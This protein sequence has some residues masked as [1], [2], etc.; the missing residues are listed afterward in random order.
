MEHKHLNIYTTKPI[1]LVDTPGLLSEKI[2]EMA[3]LVQI[4]KWMK[5]NGVKSV[6]RLIYTDRSNDIRISNPRMKC[7]EIFKALCGTEAAS[8]MVVVTTMWDLMS[9]AR[10]AAH[11]DHRFQ[12]LRC[13]PWEDVFDLELRIKKFNNTF[14]GA[15]DNLRSLGKPS[16]PGP[17]FAFVFEKDVAMHC[18]KAGQ[19]ALPLLCNRY[20]MLTGYYDDIY[21]DIKSSWALRDT[22]FKVALLKRIGDICDD[23]RCLC[24]DLCDYS[25]EYREFRDEVHFMLDTCPGATKQKQANRKEFN[26]SARWRNLRAEKTSAILPDLTSLNFLEIPLLSPLKVS[27]YV[28]VPSPGSQRPH[29]QKAA[30]IKTQVLSRESWNSIFSG[31]STPSPIR[32]EEI[33]NEDIVILY[34]PLRLC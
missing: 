5:K 2:S 9:Q 19:I 12:L 21:L 16:Q 18:T 28:L 10:L 8:R 13:F 22:E 29:R 11:R 1:I 15:L 27:N 4:R 33:A 6:D 34:H 30:I 26:W 7:W 32:M 20:D 23:I 25:E 17:A 3:V 31:D 24:S 14:D